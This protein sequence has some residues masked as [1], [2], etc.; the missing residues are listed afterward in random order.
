[1]PD[2]DALTAALAKQESR[3]VSRRGLLII[4]YQA[5]PLAPG[6]FRKYAA[7]RIG[8]RIVADH[9]VHDVTWLAK[10]G[11]EAAWSP[12]RFAEELDYVRNNPHAEALMRAFD[13]AG[14]DYGRADYGLV[15]GVPQ[16]WEINTN[17]TLPGCRL[18]KVPPLRVD[19]TRIGWENRIAAFRAADLS[20]RGAWLPLKSTALDVHRGWQRRFQWHLTRN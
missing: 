10:Y 7:Y 2:E 13:I 9:M 20:E 5:E 16:I 11:D 18:K 17:P 12:E 6:V 1:L 19:A 4:E 15:G 3:G 8:D 14:I